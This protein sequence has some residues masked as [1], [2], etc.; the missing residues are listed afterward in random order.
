MVAALLLV[1]IASTPVLPSQRR[2][3]LAS[4]DVVAPL[5]R[6]GRFSAELRGIDERGRL[7][8]AADLS[9]GSA[10]LYWVD[11]QGLEA[12][13]TKPVDA[14]LFPATSVSSPAGRVAVR[15][16]R[17]GEGSNP[18]ATAFVL[19]ADGPRPVLSLGDT[20]VEGLHVVVMN[21]LMAI[22]DDGTIVVVAGVAEK[23]GPPLPGEWI[24]AIVV[25]DAA[26]PR[27]IDRLRS[28]GQTYP[29]GVTSAG[30]VVFSAWS[31]GESG[32]IYVAGADG[33]RRRVVGPGDRL[34]SGQRL[35][36]VSGL[37]VSPTGEV[38]F[39]GCVQ[40]AA[41]YAERED[42]ATYRSRDGEVVRVAGFRERTPDG[43][44][45]DIGG[46][47]FINA[48]GDVVLRASLLAPCDD[49]PGRLCEGEASLLYFPA[50]GGIAEVGRGVSGGW[51]NAA[52]AVATTTSGGLG[53]WRTGRVATLLHRDDLAP[54]GAAFS[55]QGVEEDW[56]GGAI[57]I[58]DDG[59]VGMVVSFPDG[60]QALVCVDAEGPHA[61]LGAHDPRLALRS[62][63]PRVQCDFADGDEMYLGV[64]GSVFRTTTAAGVEEVIGP[65]DVPVG[66]DY[67]IGGWWL[68]ERDTPQ[69][70]SVN[71]HGTVV[72]IDGDD[73]LRRRHDGP[74]EVVDVP[75][76][77]LG[78]VFEAEVADDESILATIRLWSDARSWRSAARVVHVDDE[79]VRLIARRGPPHHRSDSV[80]PGAPE[81]LTIAGG[82][83][84]FVADRTDDGPWPLL[85]EVGT[86]ALRE[87]LAGPDLPG[88][89]YL[90]D[91]A[92]DGST[93]LNTD[94]YGWGRF[95]F[96]GSQLTRLSE[97][98]DFADR[99]VEPVAL[100]A[101]GVVVFL[102]RQHGRESLS[103][104]G[105]LATGRCPRVE[106]AATPTPAPAAT[107]HRRGADHDGCAI[108]P[109]GRSACWVFAGAGLLAYGRRR[110]RYGERPSLRGCG[111]ANDWGARTSLASPAAMSC[112]PCRHGVARPSAG[113][114]RAG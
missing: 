100:G 21:Q 42:C 65:D 71:R 61:V 17:P 5:G 96:D 102:E 84:G 45:F 9:D 98:D 43:A 93:L 104:S 95:L 58:A 99:E 72:A 94:Y 111:T 3:L 32:A 113:R 10:A 49:E 86:G 83:A 7:L 47:G 16:V 91:I 66:R 70:F 24:N 92:A 37:A 28:D 14:T 39:R 31:G 59:R 25:I 106:I 19:D 44:L 11:E 40:T 62:F 33:A 68:G 81:S 57:C 38:L 78:E 29:I 85:Y 26:G 56:Y 64:G 110:R 108:V 34:P 53:R 114:T 109:P 76:P 35:R 6:V 48:R 89:A 30:D 2:E 67:P 90:V 36:E 52:G 101:P 105:P 41:E 4:G 87:L 23:P 13:P 22:G 54:G 8:V 55:A 1:S 112:R 51:V 80:L 77:G 63:W 12:L 82:L 27:V 69:V 20:T 79:G 97:R 18:P 74:L 15:G 88:E 107:P 60:G 46:D 75:I 103:A 50:A 73:I